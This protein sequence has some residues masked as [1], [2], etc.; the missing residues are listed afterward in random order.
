MSRRRKPPSTSRQRVRWLWRQQQL[1]TA[2]F[3]HRL[4]RRH[5]HYD[6][7]KKFVITHRVRLN[8]GFQLAGIEPGVATVRAPSDLGFTA[9]AKE[10]LTFLADLRFELLEGKKYNI[11]VDMSSVDEI[12][13]PAAVVLLAEVTRCLLYVRKMKN[14]RGNY[15]RGD[16]ARQILADIGFFSAFGAKKP[17]ISTPPSDRV[18]VHTAF[19]NRSDGRY[20]RPF[21]ALFERMTNLPP[22]AS[23]RLYG[24]LIECMDNVRT[25]AYETHDEAAPD[26]VGE[27]WLCGFADPVR[28]QVALVFYDLGVGIPATIKRRRTVRFQSYINFTDSRILK[29]AVEI[30]LSSSSSVRHGTGLPSLREFVDLAPGGFLRVISG[31]GD[32]TYTRR[33]RLSPHTDIRPAIAGSLILWTVHATD[34][35]IL[36]PSS[37]DLADDREPLQLNLGYEDDQ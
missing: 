22:L 11:L 32:F 18:Y 5:K 26:V 25:H 14:V 35:K 8:D 37:R 10:T 12:S 28:Q 2:R 7:Y 24:A 29:R 31:N 9:H 27:W 17:P 19:G 1:T 36:A 33:F 13:L 23:K 34:S 30:G 6:P 15:P 20:T 21:L 4:A 16:R 3:K